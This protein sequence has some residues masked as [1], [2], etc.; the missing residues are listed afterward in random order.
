MVFTLEDETFEQG[1]YLYDAYPEA[2]EKRNDPLPL[3]SEEV[4]LKDARIIQRIKN[5]KDAKANVDKAIRKRKDEIA[6]EEAI[7]RKQRQQDFEKQYY[8]LLAELNSLKEEN[9]KLVTE[10][11]LIRAINQKRKKVK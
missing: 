3:T 2:A 4:R 10:V 7:A 11:E 8:E 1:K 6:Y 5:Q 9:D